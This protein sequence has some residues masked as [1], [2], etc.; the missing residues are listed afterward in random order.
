MVEKEPF[1]VNLNYFKGMVFQDP[2]WDFRTFDP[3]RD[4]R[5]A[6]ERTGK[7]VDANNPDLR[8]FKQAGGKLILIASWNSTALA[9]LQVVEYYQDIEKIMGG[10]DK[11]RDFARLFA[12]PGSR[13]CPG[14]VR[15]AEDFKA[16]EAMIDWVENGKAPESIVYSY[17]EATEGASGLASAGKVYRTRPVCAYPEVSKYKGAGD[18]N[19]AANFTCGTK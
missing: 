15:N 1:S 10:P 12:V 14:F 7:Y 17:R 6:I 13:G 16:L 3:D 8:P 18:I 4:T 2:N 11:T 19:D 5:L 9:P